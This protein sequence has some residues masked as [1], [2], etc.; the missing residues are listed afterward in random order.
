MT[1]DK[2]ELMQMEIDDYPEVTAW[3]HSNFRQALNGIAFVKKVKGINVGI[4][5]YLSKQLD[6]ILLPRA[7]RN[8]Y[9]SRSLVK[10]MEARIESVIYQNKLASGMYR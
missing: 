10:K 8:F 1:K 5:D 3:G 2:V 9:I 7:G 6:D 4:A